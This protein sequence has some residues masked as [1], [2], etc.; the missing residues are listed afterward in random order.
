MAENTAE[1]AALRQG[2]TFVWHELYSPDPDAS[3]KFYEAALGL[4]ST[5]M[6]MGE[7]GS[8]TMLTRDGKAVCGGQDRKSVV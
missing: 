2:Q 7:G 1:E 4:G 5:S 6:D 8:Y 3:K